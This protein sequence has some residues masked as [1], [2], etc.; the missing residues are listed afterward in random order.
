MNRLAEMLHTVAEQAGDLTRSMFAPL[1]ISGI[2][3]LWQGFPLGLRFWPTTH[4]AAEG[5]FVN[6][7]ALR[8][9][10]GNTGDNALGAGFAKPIIDLP[11]GF[12]GL[13]RITLDAEGAAQ[14]LNEAVQ[15]HWTDEIQQVFRDA[16]RDSK[17]IVRISKPDILDPLMTMDEAAHCSIETIPAELVDIERNP[18]NKRIIEKAV[19]HHRMV[20][21]KGDGDPENGRDP[22]VEEHDVLEIIDRE[23]FRFFDQT[24]SQ[25]LVDMAAP[26]RYGFVPLEEV[27][28]EYDTSLKGGRSDLET[29]VPFITAFHDVFT[30]GLQAHKYHS[31][32]KVKMKLSDV[33]PFIKNNFPEAV[34]ETTGKIKQNGEITWRGREI[35]FLQTEE[36]IEFLEAV[37]VL[38]DTKT[39]LEFIIDCICIASQTPEWA[40][41][42]V[43]SG[44]ANSDR[45]AQ[46]VPFVKKIE[47]KRRNFT[48]HI[49]SLCKMALLMSGTF[50]I[51]VRPTISWEVVR[52][53]DQ[54]VQMQAFQQLVMGLEVARARG[55]ISDDTYQNMLRDF[56]PSMGSNSSERSAP[57]APEIPQSTGGTPVAANVNQQ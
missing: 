26:N 13:P 29:V 35:L 57:D 34:D 53:D 54:I 7:D 17:I 11:V 43:D 40:F 10:Y 37:S 50:E 16:M 36:E 9:L 41:M 18:R 2:R 25:W 27:F 14:F 39:L 24:T 3:N 32:P 52:A 45:N 19:I 15:D 6:Y 4:P 38:G 44:S 8:A 23:R 30:Q 49:Q 1:S 20:F 22:I 46:T 12:M 21:V 47:R 42:R 51:P 33:A 28:N 31:T 55:E 56:L 5:S 48:K